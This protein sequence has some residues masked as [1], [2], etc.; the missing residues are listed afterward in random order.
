MVELRHPRS[1]EYRWTQ[2]YSKG[3]LLLTSIVSTVDHQL[4]NN[5]NNTRLLKNFMPYFALHD[6]YRCRL[7][8][9][10]ISK[11]TFLTRSQVY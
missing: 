4:S 10:E 11:Q 3:I 8:Q 1:N 9:I 6:A 2:Y 5:N 7:C